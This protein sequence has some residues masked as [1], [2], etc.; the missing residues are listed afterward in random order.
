MQYCV[1]RTAL[2]VSAGLWA[3]TAAAETATT[4]ASSID[5]AAQESAK[6][7]DSQWEVSFTPYAWIAGMKGHMDI[8]GTSDDVKIDTSF[9]DLLKVLNFGFMGAVDARHGPLVLIGDMMY[10]NAGQDVDGIASLGLVDG[11]VD[12]KMLIA[13]AAA[14]YR[15]VDKGPMFIDLF[16]G[17]RVA[18]LDLDVKLTGPSRT[19]K[20]GTSPSSISPLVGGRVRVPLGKDWG[21]A[22]YGDASGLFH[23][24]AIKGQLIGTIQYDISRRWRLAAGYRYLWVHQNKNDVE[25][26]LGMRGPIIGFTYRF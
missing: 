8:P 16:A 2:A 15:V 17:G 1:L 14:G 10:F 18:S 20:T 4:A 26:N 6:A 19:I 5:A 13:S 24:S 25:L 3:T 23:T 12:M 9:T 11:K 22:L 7:A 21:F